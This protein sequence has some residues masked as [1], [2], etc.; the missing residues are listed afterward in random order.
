MR[1]LIQHIQEADI[2]KPASA[3]EVKKRLGS[4]IYRR[5]HFPIGISGHGYTL[6]EAW[7][8]A[9]ESFSM[10]PGH[11]GDCSGVTAVKVNPDTFDEIGDEEE[12]PT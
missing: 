1:E 7:E 4:R 9:V 12:I 10:D 6:E 11:A 8:D 3:K 2:F 5:Y